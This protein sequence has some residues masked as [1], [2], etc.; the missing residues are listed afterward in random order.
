M[1]LFLFLIAFLKRADQNHAE[2]KLVVLTK[3]HPKLKVREDLADLINERNFTKMIE[4]GLRYG[5]S[6]ALLAR[7]PNIEQYYGIDPWEQQANYMDVSNDNN[8]A[9]QDRIHRNVKMRLCRLYGKHKITIIRN[10][11]ANACKLFEPKSIDFIYL[12]AR[13]DYCGI[14][15]DLNN[16]YPILKCDGL[17]GGHDYQY[18]LKGHELWMNSCE[19]NQ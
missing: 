5:R 16:Y 3:T 7:W 2:A 11:S 6:R 4:V 13:H 15:E 10:Y 9:V 17:M 1:L 8:N 12:D 14:T 19:R 18:A